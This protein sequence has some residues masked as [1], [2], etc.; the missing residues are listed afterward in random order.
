MYKIVNNNIL[1]SIKYYILYTLNNK[2]IKVH[3]KN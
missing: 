3:L 2:I 1:N